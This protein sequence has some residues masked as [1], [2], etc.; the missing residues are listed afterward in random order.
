MS[1]TQREV[2]RLSRTHHITMA[3]LTRSFLLTIIAGVLTLILGNADAP[4]WATI[5]LTVITLLAAGAS[6]VLGVLAGGQFLKIL[7]T[8]RLSH[9]DD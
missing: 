9:Y 3:M 7:R 1:P 5:P 8:N 2:D 4:L 6:L